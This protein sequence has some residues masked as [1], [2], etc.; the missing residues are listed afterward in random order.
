MKRFVTGQARGQATL[1]PERLDDFIAEDNPVRVVDVVVE[2]L[3]L[4]DFGFRRVDP[5]A[6]GRPAYHPA[7]LLKL[8]IYG[9]LNRV[10][11]SRRLER[12][13][14]RNLE[15][16]WL[17]ERLTPDH[18]TIADFRKDNGKAIR[19]VCREFIVLCRRLEL[20]SEAVVAINGSKFK[21]VNNRDRN[22]T[23]AKVKRRLE[24]I[25]E[26]IARYLSEL[27]SADR[28]ES[29]IG[30]AKRG[31]L[32]E[33]ID[34]L[35]EKIK[36]LKGIERDLHRAPDQQISQSDPDARSMATSGRGSGTVGY[37]V[38]SAV[39]P[40]HHLIVTE[41]VTNVGHDR[42]QLA[43][44][45]AKAREAI[46]GEKLTAVADRGYYKGEEILACEEAGIT[47]VLPKPQTSGNQAKGLFG[48]RDFRYL[49]EQDI[50]RCPAG[51]HLTRRATTHER[52][53]I[54]YRYWSSTCQGCAL[55]SRCT[56]GK[57]RRVTRWEHETVLDNLQARLD[58]EPEKMRLRR[59]TV[60]HPF[61]TIKAWMGYTH[62][63][64]KTL[65]R[66]K[67]EMSLH[68]L[69]YNLKRVMNILGTGFLLKAMRA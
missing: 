4:R 34:K 7:V 18:K 50:Y 21:A 31:R 22:Y 57:E 42:E 25:D 61:G 33:K 20:F 60:E 43:T 55:K 69:A 68:V 59:Q 27:D 11:S 32:E 56:P 1:F 65:P 40:T 16:M 35:K 37:N 8:Y 6:T 5:L 54:F 46:G 39:E 30:R 44:M 24:Q 58:R 62:F 26:S 38:Q 49:P 19:K 66:V 10:Q 3:E 45:A 2:A 9:Y 64:T 63:L 17:T 13:S 41:E 51:E 53:Q 36:R 48:K 28:E 15:L 29:A 52:G 23:Q 12:E 14:Q 47:T 67:T